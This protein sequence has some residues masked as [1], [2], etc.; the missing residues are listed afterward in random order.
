MCVNTLVCM[1]YCVHA[2][3][4]VHAYVMHIWNESVHGEIVY[5]CDYNIPLH[6]LKASTGIECL[7]LCQHNT[8][9]TSEIIYRIKVNVLYTVCIY[10]I[11]II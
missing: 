6:S 7:L 2:Y 4:C 3:L 11:N 10:L 9:D 5:K 1:C 8:T